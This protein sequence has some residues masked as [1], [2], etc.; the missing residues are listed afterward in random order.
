MRIPRRCGAVLLLVR[1]KMARM[2]GGIAVP[3]RH[4]V[5]AMATKVARTGHVEEAEV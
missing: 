4:H 3:L 5:M 2:V 1:W